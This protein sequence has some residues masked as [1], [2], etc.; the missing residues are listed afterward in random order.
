VGLRLAY[1]LERNLD[2]QVVVAA[3]DGGQA[4]VIGVSGRGAR[5]SSER[6]S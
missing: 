5:S 3:F 4:R 1:Q 6:F 2:A